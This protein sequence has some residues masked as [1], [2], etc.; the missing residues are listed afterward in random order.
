MQLTATVRKAMHLYSL[1]YIE[2]F[3][4]IQGQDFHIKIGELKN[5]EEIMKS[6]PLRSLEGAVSG[7]LVVA[8][9]CPDQFD[10]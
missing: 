10:S 3:G 1:C 7:T 5:I 2:I 4:K 8:A 6:F 9:D